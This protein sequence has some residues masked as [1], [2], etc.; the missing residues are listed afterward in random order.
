MAE[1]PVPVNAQF[2]D[3][4]QQA[5][6][7]AEAR[8]SEAIQ[9]QEVTAQLASSTNMDSVLDLINQSA[10]ELMGGQGAAIFRYDEERDGLV[11]ARLRNVPELGD[12]IVRAGE[13]ITVRA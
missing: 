1:P 13:G 5:R 12:L 9:L 2:I 3:Q 6:E 10:A 11:L 4:T 8:E 7:D